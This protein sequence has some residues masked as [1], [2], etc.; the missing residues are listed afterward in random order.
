MIV[1]LGSSS[2]AKLVSVL[3]INNHFL[4]RMFFLNLSFIDFKMQQ[5]CILFYFILF[6]F[7]V[8][9]YLVYNVFVLRPWEGLIKLREMSN[10]VEVGKSS[11]KFNIKSNSIICKE[12]HKLATNEFT[13][14]WYMLASLKRCTKQFDVLFFE[15]R[16]IVSLVHCKAW[17]LRFG[18]WFCI[19]IFVTH[20]SSKFRN[21][22]ELANFCMKMKL[23]FI[24]DIFAMFSPP[25]TIFF[26]FLLSL[27]FLLYS[28]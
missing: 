23:V 19:Q 17:I 22:N 10:V 1:H 24:S 18:G 5:A 28:N 25:T 2:H 21:V 9:L 26:V 11:L 6:I 8:D 3:I 20:K 27:W 13:I 4:A 15:P 7:W 12:S 14:N 16:K